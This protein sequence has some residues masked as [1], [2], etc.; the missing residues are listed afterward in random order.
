MCIARQYYNTYSTYYSQPVTIFSFNFFSPDVQHK[1]LFLCII[2]PIYTYIIDIIMPYAIICRYITIFVS[3][4][5]ILI[6]V[7]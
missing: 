3:R 4:K 6:Y 5:N 7:S 2:V 1:L